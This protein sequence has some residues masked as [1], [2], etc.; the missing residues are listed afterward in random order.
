MLGLVLSGA[1]AIPLATELNYLVRWTG[2][3]RIAQNP[4]SPQEAVWSIWLR[5]VH[6]A[7]SDTSNQNPFLYYGTDWLAFGHFA[8][9]LAFVGALIDPVRNQWLFTFGLIACVLVV[10]YALIFGAIRGIPLW[11]RL[12]DCSF[13]V[14]GMVPLILCRHWARELEQ[15]RRGLISTVGASRPGSAGVPPASSRTVPGAQ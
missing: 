10:P 6:S 5:K 2:A 3:D 13:G 4:N 9:A 8:I 12:V 11:W 7:L 15:L 1:T 14:F